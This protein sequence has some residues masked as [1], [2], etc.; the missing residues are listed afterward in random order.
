MIRRA[1]ALLAAPAALLAA[2]PAMAQNW[3]ATFADTPAQGHRVGDAEAPLQLVLFTSY[4]CPACAAFDQQSEAQLRYFY[5]HEGLA[6]LE[7][8]HL[9][10]NPVDVAAALLAECGPDDRFFANHKAI[11]QNQADWIA[12][13]QGIG[14]QQQ[15]RWGSGTVASRMRAIASDLELDE[16]MEK[17]G[18]SRTQ[19]DTCL[20]DEARAREIV[21]QSQANAAEYTIPGTPSFVLNGDMLD[22]VHN[23]LALN[24][25]LSA[26]RDSNT[27]VVE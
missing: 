11:L 2:A 10:R 7:V 6:A 16:L 1:I 27:T 13:A 26:A 14:A 15:A 17:Q 22:G 20:S 18:L 8:R 5:V 19:I 21:A 24:Q 9:I 25:A 23:W 3:N 12:R 4:T